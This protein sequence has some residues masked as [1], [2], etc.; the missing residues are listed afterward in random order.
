M[1]FS[2]KTE[3]NNMIDKDKNNKDDKNHENDVVL[4]VRN[5]SF[6][7]GTKQ[8]LFD[9]N[10]EFLKNKITALIGPSGCGK[11]TLIRS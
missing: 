5:F 11:S 3:G 1:R 2:D 7:Y 10:L 9:I 4:S 6:F 8:V